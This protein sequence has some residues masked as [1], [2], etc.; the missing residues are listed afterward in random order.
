MLDDCYASTTQ[1]DILSGF[2]ATSLL[3]WKFPWGNNDNIL[4]SFSTLIAYS[5]PSLVCLQAFIS[6]AAVDT[7]LIPNRGS[8]MRTSCE[9]GCLIC[10]CK[11]RCK[12]LHKTKCQNSSTILCT[13]KV[14]ITN[15]LVILLKKPLKKSKPLKVTT[16]FCWT[17]YR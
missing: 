4:I 1:E 3:A 7:L 6:R 15:C 16:F 8:N 17:S 2:D 10:L 13:D 5:L 11:C 14:L 9:F 12:S